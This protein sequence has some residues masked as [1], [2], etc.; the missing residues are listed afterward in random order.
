[1][2]EKNTLFTALMLAVVGAA[3][4]SASAQVAL[5][6]LWENP[7]SPGDDEQYEY[8][9][10]YGPPNY[11]LTGYAIAL[12]KGSSVNPA[13][14][15]IDEAFTL[16]GLTTDANGLLFIYHPGDSSGDSG[17]ALFAAAPA[18]PP[19]PGGSPCWDSS[20]SASKTNR[21]FTNGLAFPVVHIPTSDTSGK[22]GNDNS[23][24]Y[25]IVR[26]RPNHALNPSGTSFYAA[27]YAWRKDVKVDVDANSRLDAAFRPAQIVDEVA[28]SD[29]SGY[30]YNLPGR[31]EMSNKIS[32]TPG[33]NP[34][35]MSRLRYLGANPHLGW[36]TKPDGALVRTSLADESWLYGEHMGAFEAYGIYKH[37]YELGRLE[38]TFGGP[39]NPDGNLYTY[40]PMNPGRN[41]SPATFA[42]FFEQTNAYD[43]VNGTLRFEPYS[44]QGFSM[45]PGSFNDAPENSALAGTALAQQF[46]WVRGDFNFDGVVD[47][48]DR[49][50]IAQAAAEGWSLDEPATIIDDNN[51]PDNTADDVTYTGYLRQVENFNGV[52]AMIRM[53]LADGST[54]EWTSGQ[55][56]DTN[57][58]SPTFGKI[59]AWGGSVTAQDLAAFD[60]EFPNV[61]VAPCAADFNHVNGVTVQDIFDFL[62]AWLAGNSS[63]DFNHVNGVTVQ[64]IFDFLTAWLAGC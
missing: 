64:D 33:F 43:P 4:S 29:N 40:D 15:E 30:E 24:T 42:P 60:S 39:T 8:I 25:F 57:A 3:V 32:E 14:R 27:G 61:C 6:E 38:R 47:C 20:A 5:N 11:D 19:C 49:G 28:W 22:L 16:D 37:D 1:M 63:A 23:S 50:M 58:A 31:G 35:G 2:M 44:S 26:R 34:D 51:T 13:D 54:G 52:L 21:R 10:I 17:L 55:I 45:T 36:T 41:Q 59:I 12:A 9:E 56:T 7:P 62:T 18:L 46:R 53:N 48:T